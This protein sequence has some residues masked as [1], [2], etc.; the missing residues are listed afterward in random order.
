MH[1]PFRSE[2]T[3]DPTS[4]LGRA[5]VSSLLIIKAL[6]GGT[7]VIQSTKRSETWNSNSSTIIQVEAQRRTKISGTRSV[8]YILKPS[9]KA[10]CSRND[11]VAKYL[12][13]PLTVERLYCTRCIGD[14]TKPG[15][16]QQK[17]LEA[18]PL[19]NHRKRLLQPGCKEITQDPQGSLHARQSLE[20]RL[21]TPSRSVPKKNQTIRGSKSSRAR[22][23]LRLALKSLPP[24]RHC[25]EMSCF[26]IRFG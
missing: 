24:K 12:F 5:P 3:S 20:S 23:K 8:V 21:S 13:S 16:P 7:L 2:F 19:L 15:R 25:A 14:R 4:T 6:R 11:I 1:G 17:G 18:S 10:P 22:S 26:D 9:L